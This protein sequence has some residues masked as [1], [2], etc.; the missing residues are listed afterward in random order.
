MILIGQYDSPFVRRV[1]IALHHY[2]LPFE[3]RPWSVWGNAAQIA[4]YN[5]LRRVP[6]LLLDDGCALVETFA[7]LDSVDELVSAER[8]LA[9]RS[10][11]ARRDVLRVAALA[12]GVAD[13]AVTLLYSALDL[14][15]P[16]P[17]WSERCRTQILESFALLETER[18]ARQSMYWFGEALSHADIALACSYRFTC[19]AHPGLIAREH[20]PSL[21]A[22]ADRCEAL[23]EFRAA[24]LPITN[25]LT[26][27]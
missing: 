2:G 13:K 12:G 19:E 11:S 10:G 27:S 15:Q 5:P 4:Q 6:T 9:P 23:P 20:F 17:I 7:I 14:M 3:H 24:Y 22:Q 25:N 16:S 21:D 8:T 26:K 1:A 18:A